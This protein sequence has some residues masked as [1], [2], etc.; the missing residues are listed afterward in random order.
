MLTYILG[1]ETFRNGLQ[2]KQIKIKQNIYFFFKNHL[3]YK[4]YFEKYA[5]SNVDHEDLWQIL[6]E[7]LT[8]QKYY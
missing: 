5:Y 4:T 1:Y 8:S 7:V 3:I 6:E 2:V